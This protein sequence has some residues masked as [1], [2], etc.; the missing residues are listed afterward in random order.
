MPAVVLKTSFVYEWETGGFLDYIS[1]PSAF[2]GKLKCIA[3]ESYD[4]MNYMGNEDKI[5]MLSGNIYL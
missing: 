3:K 2:K 1:R 4:Y 5:K